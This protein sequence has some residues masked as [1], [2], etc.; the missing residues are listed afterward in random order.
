[1]TQKQC[2]HTYGLNRMDFIGATR[3]VSGTML[4]QTRQICELVAA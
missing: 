3:G 1:M 4:A 2:D